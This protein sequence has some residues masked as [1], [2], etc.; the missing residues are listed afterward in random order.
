MVRSNSGEGWQWDRNVSILKNPLVLSSLFKG[1]GLACGVLWLILEIIS[2]TMRTSMTFYILKHPLKVLDDA[3]FALLFVGII[4]FVTIVVTAIVFRNGYDAHFGVNAEGV[5][6]TPQPGQKASNDSIHRLLF[7]LGVLAGKPGAVG[8][9]MIADATQDQSV[10][11]AEVKK[12]VPYSSGL[13]ISFHDSWHCTLIIY[14]LPENYQTILAYAR[15][16]AML[17]T[18]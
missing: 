9:A 2:W 8:M 18:E 14:C 15:S 4:I 17:S 12:I 1:F 13:A 7:G 5:W 6:M 16:R 3:Q 10:A 11:W